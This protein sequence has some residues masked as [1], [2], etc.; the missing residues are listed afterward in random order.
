M[1]LIILVILA[2]LKILE[3][4]MTLKVTLFESVVTTVL[5]I[6]AIFL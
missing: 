1:E 4:A 3:T 6:M 5:E 2:F